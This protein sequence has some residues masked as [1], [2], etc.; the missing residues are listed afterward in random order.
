M[1]LF[2]F[3]RITDVSN[4]KNKLLLP[5]E[6]YENQR[7]MSLQEAVKP[8][9]ELFPEG[10]L[11]PK[12]ITALGRNQN[13]ITDLSADEAAAIM[14]YTM[15]WSERE[16]SLY[17]IL[18]KTLRME[19][20]DNLK[21]WFPYLRL[22]IGALI[23]LPTVDTQIYRGMNEAADNFYQKNSA[24]TWWGFSSCTNEREVLEVNRFLG[25][26]GNRTLFHINSSTARNVIQYS[27]YAGESEIL[28]LP[29]RF[30]KTVS[31]ERQPDG[32]TIIELEEI[33]P[34]FT[35]LAL[36]DIRAWRQFG[37][38]LSLIGICNSRNCVAHQEEVIIPLNVQTY[39]VLTD[40]D[41]SLC[42]TCRSYVDCTKLGFCA[43]EWSLDGIKQIVPQAPT[44]FRQN[45]TLARGNTLKPFDLTAVSWRKLIVEIRF[46]D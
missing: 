16:E 20:R 33:T 45:W 8:I 17:Y 31:C 29:G 12:V 27:Y 41:I 4:E 22:L 7:L 30:L 26:T 37:R 24:T 38:G 39:N 6:G 40:T 43:C 3:G 44:E 34:E 18:N 28:L 15:E 42:P 21:V 10:S 25:K 14:L 9:E 23:K 1:A 46:I 19:N 13:G 5:I 32:L 35:L 2:K 11:Q 36:P